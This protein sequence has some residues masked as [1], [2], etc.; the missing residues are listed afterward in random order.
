MI[1]IDTGPFLARYLKRDQ[2]HE[3][4]LLIWGEL[5]SSKQQTFTSNFVLDELFTLLGRKA[6][7]DFAAKQAIIILSSTH[8]NILRPDIATEKAAVS[9]FKK[10]A[11]QQ[12][13]YTDCISFALM[14]QRGIK[15]AFTFDRHFEMANFKLYNPL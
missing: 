6:D 9:H 2:Y 11:D 12:V 15:K 10:F 1:F 3:Q 7:Y 4:S 13:S 14:K 5:A 8:L